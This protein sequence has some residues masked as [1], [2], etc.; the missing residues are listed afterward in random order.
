VLSVSG[1]NP[2]NTCYKCTVQRPKTE[3]KNVAIIFCVNFGVS[4]QPSVVS[5]PSSVIRPAEAP[6]RAKKTRQNA[7]KRAKTR[8]NATLPLITDY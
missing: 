7:P 8:Q 2:E 6:A 5:H 4:R 3:M 1:K